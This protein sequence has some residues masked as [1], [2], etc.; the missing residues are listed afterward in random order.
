MENV[1]D[2]RLHPQNY[3]G[4]VLPVCVESTGCS[5]L[6]LHATCAEH[7]DN[8]KFDEEASFQLSGL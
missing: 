1:A 6:V 2:E 8:M 5:I 7:Q 4:Y 3:C